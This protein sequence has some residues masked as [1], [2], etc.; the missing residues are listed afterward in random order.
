MPRWRL[1]QQLET[2]ITWLNSFQCTTNAARASSL[3][4][5]AAF[6][7]HDNFPDAQFNAGKFWALQSMED[8]DKVPV[9]RKRW[10]WR[11]W[12]VRHDFLNLKDL[13]MYKGGFY[14]LA[15]QSWVQTSRVST[16]I[17]TCHRHFGPTAVSTNSG[18]Y[19]SAIC[20]TTTQL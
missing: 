2:Q 18:H 8:N 15:T 6:S 7:N 19:P 3:R 17:P 14:K 11:Q 1:T 13:I 10:V 9:T 20:V 16:V 4:Y 12:K 5:K